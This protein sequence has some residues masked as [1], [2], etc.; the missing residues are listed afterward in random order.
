[1]KKKQCENERWKTEIK[2]TDRIIS[3][4]DSEK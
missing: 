4:S 1:M 3:T 2:I